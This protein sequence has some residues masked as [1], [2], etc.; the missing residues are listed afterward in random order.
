MMVMIATVGRPDLVFDDDEGGHC[1][2]EVLFLV[3]CRRDRDEA[4]VQEL[5]CQK[6]LG[7]RR[8]GAANG[9]RHTHGSVV[10]SAFTVGGESRKKREYRMSVWSVDLVCP[11]RGMTERKQNK[12]NNEMG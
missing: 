6:M 8:A 12:N 2:A 5:E 7:P 10:H 1:S 4:G 9:R 3:T 11:T